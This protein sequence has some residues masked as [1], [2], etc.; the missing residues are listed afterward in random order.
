MPDLTLYDF[1][2]S[3]GSL[4]YH[5]VALSQRRGW[6]CKLL[7]AARATSDKA[8]QAKLYGRFQEIVS[9]D[10]PGSV[11]YVQTFACGVSNK[12]HNLEVSPLQREDISQV[13]LSA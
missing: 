1:Y 3:T 7:E 4:E 9:K 12:V 2:H 13:T 8:E 11:V 5:A 6:I 10:G